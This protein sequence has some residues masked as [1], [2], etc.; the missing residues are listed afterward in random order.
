[1]KVKKYYKQQI[2][3]DKALRELIYKYC[4]GNGPK[5]LKVSGKVSV[6]SINRLTRAGIVVI[7]VK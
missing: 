3:Q 6:D 7:L 5:V 1:M 4:F 2:E